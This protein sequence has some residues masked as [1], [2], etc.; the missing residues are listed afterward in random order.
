MLGSNLVVPHGFQHAQME[1]TEGCTAAEHQTGFTK[2]LMGTFQEIQFLNQGEIGEVGF[3]NPLKAGADFFQVIGDQ[4]FGAEIALLIEHG[5]G[6]TAQ[7]AVQPLIDIEHQLVNI[8]PL[9]GSAQFVVAQANHFVIVMGRS[10]LFAPFIVSC[11]TV[12]FP[13]R[14][15][16]GLVV[17][18]MFHCFQTG[19]QSSLHVVYLPPYCNY[20]LMYK[21]QAVKPFLV[22][23][24]C[25]TLILLGFT[26]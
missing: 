14:I 20:N 21:F 17:F 2:R 6:D 9:T 3:T 8:A 16:P 12:I 22:I 24:L 7:I 23:P 5:V 18:G 1:H 15:G 10:I 26:H 13:G 25:L 11:Q 19:F 4:L